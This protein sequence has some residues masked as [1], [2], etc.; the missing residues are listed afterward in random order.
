[1]EKQ[2]LQTS[3]LPLRLPTSVTKLFSLYLIVQNL[4]KKK[5]KKK[6]PMFAQ[7]ARKHNILFQVNSKMCS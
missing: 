6:L 1:M 7:Q 3:Q 5:K 4:K 2:H